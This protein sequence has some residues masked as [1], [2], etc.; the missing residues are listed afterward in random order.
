MMMLLIRRLPSQGR[1]SSLM[2]M[3]TSMLTADLV[4]MITTTGVL[5]WRHV[6]RQ[7]AA[8]VLLPSAVC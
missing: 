4:F 1:Q 6:P 8:L 7:I 3:V 2:M 5:Q